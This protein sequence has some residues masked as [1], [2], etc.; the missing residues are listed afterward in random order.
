MRMVG[1]DAW[2]EGQRQT[3]WTLITILMLLLV[4]REKNTQVSLLGQGDNQMVIVKVPSEEEVHNRWTDNESYITDFKVSMASMAEKCGLII[5]AEE[6]WHSEKLVEYSRAYHYKD[7]QVSTAL[8]KISRV[9]SEANQTIP[10]F[11][12]KIAG[13]FSA[14]SS[15]VG[16]DHVPYWAYYVTCVETAHHI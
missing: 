14:G 8:K 13:M 2:M 6:S 10:T 3:G 7:V 1:P 11:N 12:G 15:A 5:N 16:E 9:N 4:A